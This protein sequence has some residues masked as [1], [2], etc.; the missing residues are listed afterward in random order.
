MDISKWKMD[1][2][3]DGNPFSDPSWYQGGYSPFYKES[4]GI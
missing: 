3:G 2:F 1:T 4:H